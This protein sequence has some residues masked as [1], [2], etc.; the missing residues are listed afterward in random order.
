MEKL[1]LVGALPDELGGIEACRLYLE[2]LRFGE[3]E[4]SV[5]TDN[6]CGHYYPTL[7]D[8]KKIIAWLQEAVGEMEEKT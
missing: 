5:E 4:V 1:E 7:S 6:Q 2:T 8:A 3:V